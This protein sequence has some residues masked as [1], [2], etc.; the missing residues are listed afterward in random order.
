MLIF[1]K[2][3]NFR[4]LPSHHGDRKKRIGPL[5]LPMAH[6]G[7][8]HAVMKPSANSPRR[9][10]SS[11]GNRGE[12]YQNILATLKQKPILKF[13]VWPGD[14]ND[15]RARESFCSRGK[16]NCHRDHGSSSANFQNRRRT[17]MAK[18]ISTNTI[19][20]FAAKFGLINPA[21][22][23]HLKGIGGLGRKTIPRRQGFI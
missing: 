2:G 13:M 6:A 9:G 19:D 8:G 23:K 20:Q 3:G 15:P 18:I 1:R 4:H 5:F 16:R 21:L 11:G 17:P 10:T 14:L 12:A 7:K 22:K